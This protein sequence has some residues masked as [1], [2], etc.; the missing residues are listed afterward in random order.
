MPHLVL[1]VILAVLAHLAARYAGGRARARYADI[2]S[3]YQQAQGTLWA[4]SGDVRSET[5]T[6]RSSENRG[7]RHGDASQDVWHDIRPY[8]GLWGCI[9]FVLVLIRGTLIL[10]ALGAGIW[11]LFG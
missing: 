11:L 8:V 2:L 6:L 5:P 3:K 4:D 9:F 10:L 7:K 1:F